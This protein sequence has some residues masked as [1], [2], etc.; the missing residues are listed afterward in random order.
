MGRYTW[1]LISNASEPIL[2]RILWDT[3]EDCPAG[4]QVGPEIRSLYL[5]ECNVSGYGSV[6]INGKEFK[7]G[8]RSCYI[9]H[10]GDEVTLRADEVDP[11]IALWCT[12]GGARVG[13]ILKLSG[14]TAEQPFAPE[15]KFDRLLSILKRLYAIRQE[16]DMGSELLKT[17][18]LYEFLGVLSRGKTDVGRDLVCERA[19]SIME[20]EYHTNISVSDIASELGFDR[21]YFSTFFKEHTGS[22][23]YAYLTGLRIRR[24]CDLLAESSLS[25]CEVS[26]R[27]GIDP[28]NFSRIF[29]REVGV[30]PAKYTK[31]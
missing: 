16:T 24:A 3:R 8:P 31:K 14:I 18:L 25:V 13:E 30:S 11:K 19:I 9:L 28:H 6:I 10:P 17:S 21:S 15:E 7:V 27:V 22:S 4:S 5:I 26:E 12:F 20:S 23:P 2:Q 1:Q 29:K